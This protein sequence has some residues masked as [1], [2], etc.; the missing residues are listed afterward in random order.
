MVWFF[1]GF[2]CGYVLL[3]LSNI[4]R[5]IGKKYMF[6]VKVAKDHLYGK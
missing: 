3:F 2:R 4:V 5:K 1:G 6:N